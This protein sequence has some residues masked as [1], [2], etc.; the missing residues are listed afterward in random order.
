MLS[1]RQKFHELKKQKDHLMNGAYV[2]TSISRKFVNE[3]C[4]IPFEFLKNVL[5]YKV[6]NKFAHSS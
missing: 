6:S 1:S 4:D 3:W 2:R 5:D